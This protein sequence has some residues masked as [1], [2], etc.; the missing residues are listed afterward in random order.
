MKNEITEV[1]TILIYLE[2]IMSRLLARRGPGPGSVVTLTS[3][4]AAAA[5]QGQAMPGQ[6]ESLLM[7]ATLHV[8]VRLPKNE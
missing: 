6:A 3:S 5:T 2:S 8:Q 1:L 7:C 4:S